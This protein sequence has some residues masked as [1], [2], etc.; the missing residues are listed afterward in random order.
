MQSKDI[1]LKNTFLN[2]KKLLYALFFLNLLNYHIHATNYNKELELEL[3]LETE[4]E[5]E[6]EEEIAVEE[7]LKINK[8]EKSTAISKEAGFTVAAILG[9][10]LSLIFEK[11]VDDYSQSSNI[12]DGPG[13]EF[14]G[15]SAHNRRPQKLSFNKNH[16]HAHGQSDAKKAKQQTNAVSL[17]YT[18]DR[19]IEHNNTTQSCNMLKKYATKYKL[20]EM[21]K[22]MKDSEE[23]GWY[24]WALIDRAFAQDNLE[25][26]GT[27]IRY[28]ANLHIKDTDGKSIL[29]RMH[30]NLSKICKDQDSLI[31]DF[32]VKFWTNNDVSLKDQIS[33][34]DQLKAQCSA[35]EMDDNVSISFLKNNPRKSVQYSIQSTQEVLHRTLE[36]KKAALWSG[37]T[38]LHPYVAAYRLGTSQQA[39][40]FITPGPPH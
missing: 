39:L 14:V 30:E 27:L 6:E 7:N 2:S 21:I 34:F 20:A 9:Y 31:E 38:Q 11:K 10:I 16:L 25:V 5:T 32:E 17:F 15:A 28:G 36:K 40:R 3:E 26:F 35:L 1:K 22:S 12:S 24:D 8:P 13:E 4:T 29:S 19:L 33:L 18:I 23:E 37:V